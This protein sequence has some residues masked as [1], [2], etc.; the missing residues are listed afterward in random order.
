MSPGCNCKSSF[1]LRDL[2]ICL[3]SILVT[4]DQLSFT[5]RKTSTCECLAS[6]VNPPAI[7]TAADTVVYPA[8]VVLS[9]A[10][11]LPEGKKIGFI[12]IPQI[13]RH[14]GLGKNLR[15]GLLQFFLYF[16][17]GFPLHL[18]V[19]D[20]LQGDKT[21][22]LDGHGL[23]EIRGEFKLQIQ[24]VAVLNFVPGSAALKAIRIRGVHSVKVIDAVT[25]SIRD[26]VRLRGRSLFLVDPPSAKRAEG[27]ENH[28]I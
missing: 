8:Q 23:V 24:H 7:A 5:R 18:K 22:R 28:A 21:I 14:F 17:D 9:R 15:V 2:S 20:F 6:V 12:E 25:E 19:A 10:G 11:H 27:K 26:R 16:G 4:D 3:R 1:K 13:D